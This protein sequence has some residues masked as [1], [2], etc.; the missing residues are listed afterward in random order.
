MQTIQEPGESNQPQF[1]FHPKNV[2]LV[3]VLF[4]LSLLFLSLSAAFVYTRVQSNLPPLRLPTIF[5]FNTLILIASSWTMIRAKKAFLADDTKG[6]QKSLLI[7]VVLSIVFLFAQI[8]GWR[9]LF[10]QNI[11]INSGNAASYLYIISFLHFAHVIGGLPFLGI[12]LWNAYRHMKEPV[13][14][15][16]YFSDPEKRLLLR[17]LTMYWHFLDGLWIYLV[18]FFWVNYLIQ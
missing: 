17:L 4:S 5:L 1:Q 14:V 11:F 10:S 9:M 16:V 6:Y 15:L 12:F 18:V 8:Q 2:L 7:T 3:L 13:S